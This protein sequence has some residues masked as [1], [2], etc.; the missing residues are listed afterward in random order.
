MSLPSEGQS[1]SAN[2][3]SSTYLNSRPRY[4][5]LR[6]FK[7]VRHIG[8]LVPARCCLCVTLYITLRRWNFRMDGQWL[9]DH[10][11]RCARWQH[12]AMWRRGK[13]AGFDTVAPP[14]II[15]TLHGD[16]VQR[17]SDSPKLMMLPRS[18]IPSSV[19]QLLLRTSS[20]TVIPV[21]YSERPISFTALDGRWLKQESLLFSNWRLYRINNHIY[22]PIMVKH[23]SDTQR[24]VVSLRQLMPVL[25]RRYAK[26]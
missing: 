13:F 15:I 6:V 12:S 17:F 24:C 10:A 18:L 9:W 1:L 20:A 4:N 26:T 21:D 14:V 11:I 19:L 23:S 2:Q 5:Y 3:I 22:S 7:N 25:V 16:N 8:M